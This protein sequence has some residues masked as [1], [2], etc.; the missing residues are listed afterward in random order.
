[1]PSSPA[2]DA[3]TIPPASHHQPGE[4]PASKRAPDST[5]DCTSRRHAPTS[6]KTTAAISAP[7]PFNNASVP[8]IQIHAA[9][10]DS[11]TNAPR[12]I[13]GHSPND[14]C[15]HGRS[16]RRAI[17]ARTRCSSDTGARSTGCPRSTACNAFSRGS[18]KCSSVMAECAACGFRR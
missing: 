16:A 17:S 11:A 15:H 3:A 10:P 5:T 1:M 14:R 18:S 2:A 4:T 8:A 6:R 9:H 7:G 12:T 13:T